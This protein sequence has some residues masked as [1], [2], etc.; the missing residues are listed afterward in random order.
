MS[1][2]ERPIL[3]SGP[4]V[5]SILEG[6]K[7]QTRRIDKPFK[8]PY[9]VGDRLWVRE[10]WTPTDGDNEC[11]FRA[12]IKD[13]TD[14]SPE[15]IANIRWKPSTHMPRWASRITLVVTA[16]RKERLQDITCADAIA[17][18]VKINHDCATPD[19]RVGFR[20]IW[21]TLY[22]P[23]AWDANPMVWRVVFKVAL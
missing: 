17:E 18:G 1:V 2:I 7:T 6:K 9:V 13:D 19:P 5:L 14:Y 23:S 16:V 20:D 15:E 11:L 10:T 8:I 12:T 3:F 21:F 4:M 22:G